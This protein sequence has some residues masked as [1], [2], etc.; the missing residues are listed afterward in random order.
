MAKTTAAPAAAA[1]NSKYADILA[2]YRTHAGD[3]GSTPVQIVT[4]TE[5]IQDITA[6]LQAH[7]NDNH[8]RMGLLSLVN[9]RRRLLR[10]LESKKRDT[11][12]SILA[13][14]GLRR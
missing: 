14:L 7:T 11:Y 8:S 13:D 2:K 6:H 10:Y 12:L 1:A 5:R 4:L 3:N 9:K